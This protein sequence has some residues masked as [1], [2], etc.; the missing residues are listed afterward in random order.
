MPWPYNLDGMELHA[1]AAIAV[2]IPRQQSVPIYLVTGAGKRLADSDYENIISS[3]S[4]VG[5][6]IILGDRSYIVTSATIQSFLI[7]FDR[8]IVLVVNVNYGTNPP[9]VTIPALTPVSLASSSNAL[10]KIWGRLVEASSSED[11]IEENGQPKTVFKQFVSYEVRGEPIGVSTFDRLFDENGIEW[12]ITAID[13]LP[14][15][16]RRRQ[17]S[18]ERVLP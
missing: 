11:V 2:A 6:T 4:P 13:D 8:P 17:I 9:R 15:Q 1:I 7:G 14:F 3:G 12:N 5:Q 16:P 18:A 10:T